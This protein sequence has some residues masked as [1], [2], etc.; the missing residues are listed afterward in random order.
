MQWDLADGNLVCDELKAS[1]G[2]RRPHT[3]NCVKWLNFLGYN[4]ETEVT[5]TTNT[6]LLHSH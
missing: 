4:L 1:E 2:F 5:L 3:E 6:R